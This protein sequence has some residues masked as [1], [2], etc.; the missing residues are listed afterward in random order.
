MGKKVCAIAIKAGLIDESDCI[1]IEGI[2]HA[3]IYRV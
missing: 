2:P 1:V 3:Q